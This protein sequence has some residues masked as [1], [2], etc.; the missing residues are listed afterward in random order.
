MRLFEKNTANF[1]VSL[2]LSFVDTAVAFDSRFA[3]ID[4]V[5]IRFYEYESLDEPSYEWTHEN[6]AKLCRDI[7]TAIAWSKAPDAG[8]KTFGD[9]H[10]DVYHHLFQIDNQEYKRG[11][12]VSLRRVLEEIRWLAEEVK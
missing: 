2:L 7:D 11:D 3:I 9:V 12:L 6:F 10:V 4:P 8:E 1:D 5:S